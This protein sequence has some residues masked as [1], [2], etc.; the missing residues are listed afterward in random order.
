[1]C[2]PSTDLTRNKLHYQS[3]LEN[4]RGNT[5]N[6]LPKTLIPPSGRAVV[7]HVIKYRWITHS[8]NSL[9]TLLSTDFSE[10]LQSDESNKN[11][12]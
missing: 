10:L 7:M 3:N 6:R 5:K 12:M 2:C 1:M 9:S 4:Y 8:D 11:T